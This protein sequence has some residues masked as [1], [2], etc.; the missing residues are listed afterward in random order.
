MGYEGGPTTVTVNG[1]SPTQGITLT[2]ISGFVSKPEHQETVTPTAGGL[3]TNSD[4]GSNFKMNIPAN[5][6]GTGSNAV[7]VKTQTYTTLPN[8]SSGS[9]LA[10]NGLSFSAVDSSGQPIKT[11]NS[12]ITIVI[13]YTEADIP[14]GKTEADL[15]FGTWNGTDYETLPTT[16]DTVN[17]TLTVTISHFSSFAPLVQG[18][19]A[20]TP[21]ASTAVTASSGG[22]GGAP[23]SVSISLVKPRAQIIYPDGRIVYVDQLAGESAASAGKSASAGTNASASASAKFT[24]LLKQGSR[25]T[26]VKRLQK[27]LGVEETGFFGP[28][29]RAAV[30][31]FQIKN[32]IAKK[33]EAGFGTLGPQNAGKDCGSV[34]IQRKRA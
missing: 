18:D 14:T 27:L 6:L 22:G 19:V 11:L 20:A 34:R 32:G 23:G 21:A 26:D 31:Q 5:A 9:V 13:P 30:E 3:L 7:T 10:K 12:P 2:A 24:A 25:G 28:L 4:I 1:N 29:T 17:N 15:V 8:P 16:V 33:G